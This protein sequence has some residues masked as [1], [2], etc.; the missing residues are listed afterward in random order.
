MKRDYS[1]VNKGNILNCEQLR[2]GDF[3]K[4]SDNLYF[5]VRGDIH[6]PRYIIAFLRYVQETE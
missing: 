4:T 2:E 5:E 6:P 1:A 3:L